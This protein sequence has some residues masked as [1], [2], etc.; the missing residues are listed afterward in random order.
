MALVETLLL[1]VKVRWIELQI[2]SRLEKYSMNVA[3]DP[4]Q[5][6]GAPI[7]RLLLTTS[8]HLLSIPRLF[9]Q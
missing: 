2:K 4:Q 1:L 6:I 5:P 8:P 3:C 7:S 9:N